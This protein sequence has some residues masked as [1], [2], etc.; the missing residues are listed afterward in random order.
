MAKIRA[1]YPAAL[2]GSIL[3]GDD[4]KMPA[5]EASPGKA[6]RR[7]RMRRR[8]ALVLGLGIVLP[9]FTLIYAVL[10]WSMSL[11]APRHGWSETGPAT[12]N[13]LGLIPTAVGFAGLI[14]VLSVMMAQV[15]KLPEVIEFDEGERLLTATSRVLITHGPFALSRNPMYISGAFVL[16]G[17]ALFYGS[18]VILIVTVV[19]WTLA[20]FFKVP[21]EER[22][23][24]ARFGDAY[25]SYKARV[26][27]WIGLPR[28]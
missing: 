8:T 17:W 19:G 28:R 2:D 26:P 25:R 18:V 21:Q 16:L 3:T 9:A 11:L 7:I 1:S 15:P 4:N 27:R 5:P 6:S 13:L 10:P 22:G 24:E 14:W 20:H 12:L 23:L